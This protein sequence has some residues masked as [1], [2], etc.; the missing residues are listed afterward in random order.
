MEAEEVKNSPN[1]FTTLSDWDF[2]APCSKKDC[3]GRVHS[4]ILLRKQRTPQECYCGE[5]QDKLHL[6]DKM[7]DNSNL[8]HMVSEWVAESILKEVCKS[9]YNGKSGFSAT[10]DGSTHQLIY[11][12]NSSKRIERAIECIIKINEYIDRTDLGLEEIGI[13]I[14]NGSTAIQISQSE[15]ED[16]SQGVF[17]ALASVVRDEIKHRIRSLRT[18]DP[19]MNESEGASSNGKRALDDWAEKISTH[20]LY[21]VQK[22]DGI[23]SIQSS[24]YS[25]LASPGRE[26][27][28]CLSE[29]ATEFVDGLIEEG[30]GLLTEFYGTE[31]VP[32][33]VCQ[34]RD[35]ALDE[36]RLAVGGYLTKAMR[37]RMNIVPREST[38][39]RLGMSRI[40]ISEEAL[41]T[42]NIAQRTE[43]KVS[44][45]MLE[46]QFR[47]LFKMISDAC[48]QALEG[49]EDGGELV[50]NINEGFEQ[51]L[52]SL[53][54]PHSMEMWMRQIICGQ[55]LLENED[56]EGRFYHP[57]RMDHRGRMYTSST[58]LDPQGDD[59]SRGLIRLGR[60][61][62]LDQEG[63][64]WLR[65]A[66]AKIWEGLDGGPAK[67]AAFSGLLRHTEEH[68]SPSSGC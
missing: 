4:N 46:L 20:I 63:W 15:P 47:S 54:D 13:G 56:I 3:N 49:I 50:I 35:W 26:A 23:I 58:W 22:H 34:P 59:F 5:M 42:I 7:E 62:K 6:Y 51:R 39:R 27:A 30:D 12:G 11:S 24:Q 10:V 53:P 57:L 64:K 44:E 28:S 16:D 55:G 19:A 37:E 8:F 66:V 68:E 29:E 67:E 33:M 14:G 36:D 52:D 60:S 25:G 9:R 17:Y 18:D 40:S 45:R 32:P 21:A 65:I 31:T 41:E 1:S 38:H 48:D 43:F 2:S 61:R